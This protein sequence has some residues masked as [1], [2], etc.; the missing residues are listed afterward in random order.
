MK[1]TLIACMLLGACFFSFSQGVFTNHT[2]AA[3]QKVMVDF[4]HRLENIKGSPLNR[5]KNVSS[6]IS[7][8]DIPGA[9]ESKVLQYQTAK[10][11]YIGWNCLLYASPKFEDASKK[12][13]ELF[14][15]IHN[16]IIRI[17]AE[18]PFILTGAYEQPCAEK[19][20]Q[21][22][23]FQLLPSPVALQKVK[24]DLAFRQDNDQWQV[25]IAVYEQPDQQA[26]SFVSYDNTNH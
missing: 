10:G 12:F 15:D 11:S 6:F 20:F 26:L 4:P 9:V 1:T 7:N 22:I 21:S 14:N 17:E 24:V 3:L 2:N 23:N 13:K 19:A 5:E 25:Y 18:R 16:T 8:I